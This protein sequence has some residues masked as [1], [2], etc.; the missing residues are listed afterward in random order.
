MKRLNLLFCVYFVFLSALC[1]AQ[2]NQTDSLKY[3]LTTAAEDSSKVDIL[4]ELSKSHLNASPN[5]AISYGMEAKSLAEKVKY[6]NGLAY[7]LKNI[8][9]GYYMKGQY[10]ETLDYWTQSLNVFEA[11]G[12]EVGFANLLNNLGAVHFNR[13][14]DAKALEYYLKSLQVSE[15]TGDELRIATAMQNI[16]VVY[17]NKEATHDKALEYFLKALPLCEKLE[18]KDAIGVTSVNIGEIYLEKND[19]KTALFYFNK[20][21]KAYG[22]TENVIYSLNSIGKAYNRKTDYQTALYYHEQALE[23]AKRINARLDLVQSYLGIA[24]TYSNEGKY[25]PALSSYKHAET[26][27][28]EI[29]SNYELK[30]IYQGQAFS[31]AKLAD[32]SNAY[33]YQTLFAG[34]KDTLYNIETDKKLTGL[35]FNFDIQKKQSEIDLLTKDK[36]L[37]DLDLQR[38][39]LARNALLI[40]LILVFFIA[41][42]IFRN[43]LNKIKTNKILDKQNAEIEGLLLNILPSEVAQEL[44][45]DG[46]ATPR[47]YESVSVLFTDFRGFTTIAD[48]LSPQDLV[49]ELNTCF[50]AFD[51]IIEKYNLEKIKTIGDSYMC[52]GGIPSHD[53][54]HYIN[55]VR[56]GLEIQEYI[57]NNNQ[58]RNA[59]GLTPWDLRIGIHTGPVVAGVVGKKKYAYDIW[60]S[61]VNIASRMESNGEPGQVNVSASTYELIKDKFSCAYRGKIYAKNVGEIDMYFVQREINYKTF[62]PTES[63]ISSKV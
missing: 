21:L 42:I 39:K 45:R 41:F 10:L 50:V 19:I 38:Q 49:A 58:K 53:E 22:N 35:Q 20:S 62:T 2:N 11:I 6:K 44:Q 8:G 13:G 47:Y 55:I 7:A 18:D 3:A 33:K 37:Q 48:K 54:S 63:S 9:M 61:T 29:K 27:E 59:A 28:K 52:A 14:D 51:N 46:Q 12:D 26:I 60:G 16:G 5:D 15:Q 4:L 25:E 23:K 40:G 17:L 24:D 32:F 56:A 36:A 57:I 43:Y 31:Y 34:I 1:F 30:S